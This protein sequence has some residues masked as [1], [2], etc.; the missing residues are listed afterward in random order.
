MHGL[1]EEVLPER[2]VAQFHEAKENCNETLMLRAIDDLRE[3]DRFDI[4]DELEQEMLDMCPDCFDTG[5]VQVWRDVDDM[6]ELKCARC[7][8][9][10]YENEE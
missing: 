2:L 9:E 8:Q 4:A 1:I 3:F 6:V 5:K 7:S 10:D